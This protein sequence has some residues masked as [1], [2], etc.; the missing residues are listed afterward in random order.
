[1]PL[2]DYRQEVEGAKLFLKGQNRKV[3]KAMREKVKTAAEEGKFEE[4]V[5]LRDS[6]EAIKSILQKQAVINDTSEK[7]WDAVGYYGDERGCLIE[8]VHVRAGRV[9]GTRPHFLPHFDPNDLA[10]DSREWMVDFLNQ[11]YEDNFIP[12]E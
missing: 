11:Y 1:I 5:R 2:E 9:I 10:E 8:T 7:D 12:D 3:V 6:I 4:A